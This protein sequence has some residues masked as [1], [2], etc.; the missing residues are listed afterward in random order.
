MLVKSKQTGRLLNVPDA[1]YRANPHLYQVEEEQTQQQPQMPQQDFMSQALNFGKN[2]A[3]SMLSPFIK[4]AQNVGGAGYELFR[5]GK[6]ALGDKN[7]YVNQQSGQVVENPFL[8]RQRLQSIT[9]NPAAEVARNTAGIASYAVPYGK[10][11]PGVA[12]FLSKAV[13]PGALQGGLFASSK[14]GATTED[15]GGATVGGGLFGGALYGLGKLLGGFKGAGAG[16]RKT[17]LNPYEAAGNAPY[18]PAKMDEMT[19]LA[20]EL[21]LS[22]GSNSQWGQLNKAWDITSQQVKDQLKGQK[23]QALF[24]TAV[25]DF[26]D[27]LIKSNVPTSDPAFAKESTLL[28]ERLKGIFKSGSASVEDIYNF[29]SELRGELSKIFDKANPNIK[30]KLK[31]N[32]FQSLKTT[33]DDL[34][35]EVRALNEREA[36]MFDLAKGLAKNAGPAERFGIPIPKEPFQ[37]GADSLGR[38]FGKIGG[39]EGVVSNI[40]KSPLTIPAGREVLRNL[41]GQQGPQT[42]QPTIPTPPSGIPTM[43]T[44]TQGQG[45][46][47]KIT[48]SQLQRILLSP[49]VSDKDKAQFK[50][51]YE[52]QQAQGEGGKQTD[53]QRAADQ[54]TQL[55]NTALNQLPIIKDKVGLGG[56]GLRTAGFMSAFN[57]ADQ[58]VLNFTNSIYQIKASIAKARAGTSFTPNEERLLNMYTPNEGDSYQSLVTKLNGLSTLFNNK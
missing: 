8:S 11:I 34:V 18:A 21:K 46:E 28:L 55:T 49:N 16:L 58:D 19:A 15:V 24:K 6:Q 25:K 9:Q 27:T 39:G 51:I 36:Q 22:G 41:V 13:L 42:Q 37:W 44:Q 32:L 17:V 2:T 35:P 48:S 23:T 12:P 30:E 10:T 52:T 4:T 20:N 45:G 29:K 38:L 40:Q 50:Y 54:V 14:E 1:F 53:A 33:L 31:E 5:A 43:D 7:A 47:W 57:K 26:E 3:L 56:I